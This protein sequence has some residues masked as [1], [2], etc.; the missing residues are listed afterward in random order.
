MLNEGISFLPTYVAGVAGL[1]W[2]GQFTLDF[3]VYPAL[4]GAWV[5]WRHR[6]SGMGFGLAILVSLCGLCLL[7]PYL[8]WASFKSESV[9][10]LLLGERA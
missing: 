5:A 9:E 4:T 2:P 7:G 10:A 6:F 8:L 1:G 3:T